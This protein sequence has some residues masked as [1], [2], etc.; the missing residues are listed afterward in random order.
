MN[1]L[2][3]SSFNSS[4][5]R[6]QVRILRDLGVQVTSIPV[7]RTNFDET[8]KAKI[9]DKLP[10][11]SDTKHSFMNYMLTSTAYY[12]RVLSK[13]LINQYDIVHTNSGMVAPFGLLQHNR[14]LICTFWGDDILGD[15]LYGIQPR[16]SSFCA[17]KADSVIVRSAEMQ[18]AL[19]TEAK[20]IPSGVDLDKFFP[21]DYQIACDKINWKNTNKH[22]LFPY[23]PNKTKKRY[24]F[25]KTIV[26]EVNQKYDSDVHFKSF[27]GVPHNKMHLY[28]S[29]ADVLLLTSLR[30]GSPNT[31]KEAMA[32]NL[33]VVS[34]DVGD[35]RERLGPVENSY[36]CDHD[37]ELVD[38]VIEV[39]ESGERSNGRE[40][41]DEVSLERMGERII[42][43]Y[44][45]VL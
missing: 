21:V 27:T 40:F 3:L 35:V 26:D 34:T 24:D 10:L 41:V 43:V 13:S 31:V 23:S 38:A 12:P 44:E 8:R 6:G 18:S 29:A 36:V 4:F 17:K 22:V 5:Y 1:V 25:A 39:L 28:Y 16:I 37:E 20:I 9:L 42:D 11:V 15:R 30:E 33:P 2:S 32:C 14:P 45:S 19:Q 7:R